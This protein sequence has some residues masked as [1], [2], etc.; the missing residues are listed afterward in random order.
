MSR[1]APGIRKHQKGYKKNVRLGCAEKCYKTPSSAYGIAM[2]LMNSPQLWLHVC[3]QQP[4]LNSACRQREG[5]RGREK[6]GGRRRGG[7]RGGRE[8]SLPGRRGGGSDRSW[9]GDR[10]GNYDQN[11][12]HTWWSC[13]RPVRKWVIFFLKP[14]LEPR[15]HCIHLAELDLS[16][17]YSSTLHVKFDD[18]SLCVFLLCYLV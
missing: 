18:K 13:W 5:G 9:A 7:E 10:R 11:T 12:L 4:W 1:P 15:L 16:S 8:R 17:S 2:Q 3:T 14:I 6:E